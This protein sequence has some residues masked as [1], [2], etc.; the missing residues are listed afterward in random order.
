MCIRDSTY[1]HGHC[2]PTRREG[3]RIAMNRGRLRVYLGA[4]PGVGKTYAMLGEG[5]RRAERGTDVVVGFVETHDRLHTAA[6]LDGLE[7]VPRRQ[8]SYRDTTFPE[9]DIDAVLARRPKVAL[10]DV[11]A[12]RRCPSREMWC[13]D[14]RS[15]VAARSRGRRAWRRC[16]GGRVSLRTRPPRLFR[17]RP[18]GD[19]LRAWRRS[20]S[21]IHI[22]EPTRRTPISYAV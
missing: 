6:M 10:V 19:P 17:V 21:L 8:I 22:S 2:S 5:H 14:R 3:A 1:Q 11:P 16:A 4:A 7:I 13:P 18:G 15:G 9:M 20:L 12:R